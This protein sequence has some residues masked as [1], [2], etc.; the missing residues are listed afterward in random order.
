MAETLQVQLVSRCREPAHSKV[1]SSLFSVPIS[2][3]R[4]ALSELV[5]VLLSLEPAV[6][7]DFM[8]DGTFLR[9][10]LEGYV[11]ESKGTLSAET[12]LVIEYT[13]ALARPQPDVL[14]NQ[15]D[16]IADLAIG[17]TKFL[18]KAFQVKGK[19]GRKARANNALPFL[20]SAS[21]DGL[22]RIR[23]LREDGA[24]ASDAAPLIAAGHKAAVK[25]VAVSGST[26][27]S[28]GRDHGVALYELDPTKPHARSTSKGVVLPSA[29][30]AHD[31]T[32]ESVAFHPLG[33]TFI[34]G[35]WDGKVQV[36]NASIAAAVEAAASS[37]TAGGDDDDGRPAK[38]AKSGKAAASLADPAPLSPL[39]TLEGHTGAVT[40]ALFENF[41][42][43]TNALSASWDHS[44]RVWDVPSG[45]NAT[46]IATETAVLDIG[47]CSAPSSSAT[48]TAHAGPVVRL[49]D[50]RTQDPASA[51]FK[52]HGGFVPAVA[53]M[54]GSA[55]HF[56]TAAH[57]GKVR[58][59]DIRSPSIP[60]YSVAVHSD[61]VFSLAWLSETVILTG[62]ADCTVSRV[63]LGDGLSVQPM[64]VAS[65]I[66][67]E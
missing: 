56:A 55:V 20:A 45:A 27:V 12:V 17:A 51:K 35:A 21:Y 26:L 62:S 1:P 65:N 29:T 41:G 37:A 19:G 40:T 23:P 2:S 49:W 28:A 22:V 8:I 31:D 57:D 47:L 14:E 13:E 42:D 6:P 39:I 7:F 67:S 53:W 44:L 60:L 3:T 4:Y 63:V 9:T 61:K 30:G 16:W 15:D 46:I 11:L 48:L 59:W 43:G 24:Y 52:G 66:D 33:M 38:R 32:V 58:V 34:T 25:A 10:T 54:P 50:F 18:P 64:A 5:N 36:Y